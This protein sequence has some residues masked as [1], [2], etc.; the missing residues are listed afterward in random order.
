MQKY[1]N[2]Q[3][4]YSFPN[5]F[6]LVKTSFIFLTGTSRKT[7]DSYCCNRHEIFSD[8]LRIWEASRVISF[9]KLLTTILTYNKTFWWL[10]LVTKV[11]KCSFFRSTLR[12]RIRL[13]SPKPKVQTPDSIGDASMAGSRDSFSPLPPKVGR[14]NAF[15][16]E[17]TMIGTR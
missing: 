14:T 9:H 6:V 8:T 11:N 10:Q 13:V 12:K 15:K 2:R 7:N 17:S 4:M 16:R 1:K 5:S 3:M